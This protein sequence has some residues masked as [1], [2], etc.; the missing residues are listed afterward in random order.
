MFEVKLQ[1]YWADVDA[2]GTVYFPHFFKF[3]EHAEE[4]MFRSA[5][6]E[7]QALLRANHVWLP[8]VEAFSKFSKPSQLGSAIRVR[9]KP[10]IKGEK[11][12]QYSFQIVA[13]ATGEDLAKGYI[14]VVCVDDATFKSTRLP[15][16]VRD[17]VL[18]HA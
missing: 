17:I 15:D 7:L 9:L 18:Q 13:D 14:T 12:I 1:T 5:G 10:E 3:A 4:E 11:T 6:K 2:A 8:R 16:A